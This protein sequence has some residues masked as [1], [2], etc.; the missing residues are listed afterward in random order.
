MING[1]IILES[2]HLERLFT[3][4]QTL[5]FNKA[6]YFIS[7]VFKEEITELAKK[8]KHKKSARIRITISRSDGGLYDAEDHNPNYLIQT[9][10]MNSVT[11]RLNENGLVMDVY[12]K[13]K[14]VCDDFSH[15]KSN[16][17]LCYAMGALWAKENKLNDVV[18]LNPYN[19]I[20]DTTIA[21]LFMVKDGVIKTPALTE[22]CIAG[23]TRKYL[24]KCMRE[25][26]MPVEE[27]SIAVDDLLQASEVF[28]T[29]SIFGIKWVKTMGKSNYTNQL[30]AVLHKKFIEPLFKQ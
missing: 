21:N 26:G 14:K 22:G 20:A 12:T 28:L 27:T 23:V 25:E 2:Y 1:K 30:S 3:S 5:Q 9:W 24:L 18:L 4:L 19:K 7:D 29:N 13:A 6:S 17:F 10:D 15:I 8:N 11:N 16:N